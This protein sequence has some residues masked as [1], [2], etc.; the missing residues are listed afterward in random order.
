MKTKSHKKH[1]A[2]LLAVIGLT[3]SA[4]AATTSQCLAM[5]MIMDRQT[6]SRLASGRITVIQAMAEMSFN[7]EAYNSCMANAVKLH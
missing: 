4:Y 6:K 7:R 1:T 5:Y 3:I 2:A